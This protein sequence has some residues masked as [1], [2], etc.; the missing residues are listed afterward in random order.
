MSKFDAG[1]LVYYPDKG[2]QVFQLEHYDGLGP[3]PVCI[4]FYDD[5]DDGDDEPAM[6][7][8]TSE[9]CLLSRVELPKI[10]HA[11]EENH[12]LLEKLYG[13]EFQKPPTKPSSRAIIKAMLERGDKCIPCY[14][15]DVFNNPFHI[16]KWVFICTISDSRFLANNNESW[17][18]ATPFDPKTGE[19]ITELP[20]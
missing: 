5:D 6:E 20:Q 15:S 13:K 11:T 14:V 4:C 7:S 18:Y 19:P 1:D 9:G 3:S 10:F 8:F 12:A 17:K 2:T 16:H